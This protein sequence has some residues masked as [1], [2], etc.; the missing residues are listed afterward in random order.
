MAQLKIK[1]YR[2]AAIG[3]HVSNGLAR[4]QFVVRPH[5][6]ASQ[7]PPAPDRSQWLSPGSRLVRSYG[8][9]R[10]KEPCRRRGRSP[11]R[12]A[13]L[14]RKGRD[15]GAFG[16]RPTHRGSD[17]RLQQGT[18]PRP[19]REPEFSAVT[20]TTDGSVAAALLPERL[21]PGQQR[22]EV[23]GLAGDLRPAGF[24]GSRKFRRR[25]RP[26]LLFLGQRASSRSR[27]ATVEV[28]PRCRRPR[29][30]V[31]QSLRVCF[32]RIDPP[33][34]LGGLGIDRRQRGARS[35]WSRAPRPSASS[36]RIASAGGMSCCSRSSTPR[37][38]VTAM[39]VIARNPRSA[40]VFGGQLRD[41]RI[42][43]G[44]LPLQT[45]NAGRGGDQLLAQAAASAA[46]WSLFSLAEA[47][48]GVSCFSSALTGFSVAGHWTAIWP[49]PCRARRG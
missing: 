17:H 35:A 22:L 21:N 20:V 39:P 42:G 18:L 23:G 27:R 11:G 31:L 10:R 38:L 32:K 30:A 36:G 37:S 41:A 34:Q 48:S 29:P 14:H 6:H 12:R 5:R 49:A 44:L 9:A 19:P 3:W 16:I 7:V 47:S 25:P 13:G 33:R 15:F 28:W 2:S 1:P 46:S 4:Q 26:R 24:S 8:K 45:F 43:I 40:V